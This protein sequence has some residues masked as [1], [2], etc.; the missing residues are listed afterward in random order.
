MNWRS[1]FLLLAALLSVSVLA[2]AE[3][4][5]VDDRGGRVVLPAP[6]QRILSLAPHT[7]EMLFEAGAGSH[8][9]GTIRYADYPEAARRIPRV[10]DYASVDMERVIGMKPDLVV[11]WL[12][13]NSEK[14]L[15]ML[16]RLGVPM[17]YSSPGKL[18]DI[19]ATLLKLGRLAGT[20]DDAR[21]AAGAFDKRLSAMRERYSGRRIVPVFYQAWK[22]PLMTINGGQI[23]SDVMRLCGASNVFADDKLLVPTVDPE[24]VIRRRPE[25]IIATGD[26]H[27]QP[28]DVFSVW[29][30]FPAFAPTARGNL[31]LL[32]TDALVRPSARMLDGASALC[33]AVDKL[34]E[35]RR[36]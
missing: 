8:I 5:V 3:L 4:S 27:A 24:A 6:A 15:D 26:D 35:G 20:E 33:D 23:I 22:R 17:F 7:T 1:I 10:G 31:V 32:H 30:G 9:V 16:R 12:H 18:E 13:G 36:S 28:D 11:V 34:R 25:A 29:K 2:R 21:R 19:P 14:H